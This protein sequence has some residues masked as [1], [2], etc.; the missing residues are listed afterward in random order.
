MLKKS[1][2]FSMSPW[3]CFSRFLRTTEEL[4]YQSTFSWVL[5][6]SEIL[7]IVSSATVQEDSHR[8]LEKEWEGIKYICHLFDFKSEQG[9][10]IIGGLT[11]SILIEA[12]S[13]VFHRRPSFSQHLPD[14]SQL[15]LALSAMPMV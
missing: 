12:A 14:F 1:M 4:N 6:I 5:I 15:Q 8:C 13:I 2:P 10:F 7:L 11:A 3:R 9:T